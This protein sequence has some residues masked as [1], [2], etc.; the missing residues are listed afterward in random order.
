MN[1]I[2]SSGWLEYLADGPN[3]DYFQP[4]LRQTDRLIV[5]TISIAEVFKA[6]F[7]QRGEQPALQAVALMRQGQIVPLD[8]PIALLAARLGHQLKLALADSVILATAQS[9]RAT[10][11]TQD[12]DFESIAGVKFRR[13]ASQP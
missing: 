7:R 1:L 4:L 11:W 5:P 10:L 2:D 13:K 8:E 9:H 12:A 6:I 3:A